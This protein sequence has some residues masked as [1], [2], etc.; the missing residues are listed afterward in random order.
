MVTIAMSLTLIWLDTV[1]ALYDITLFKRYD[2]GMKFMREYAL[3][4]Q[5]SGDGRTIDH[6]GCSVY[7]SDKDGKYMRLTIDLTVNLLNRV[8]ICG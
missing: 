3:E 8:E 2:D 5:K 1:G 4:M 6:N 7:V